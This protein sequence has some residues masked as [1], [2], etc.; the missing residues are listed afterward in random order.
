[1]LNNTLGEKPVQIAIQK[2]LSKMKNLEYADFIESFNMPE[3]NCG[4]RFLN[5][6]DIIYNW[7]ASEKYPVVLVRR[8]KEN[9]SIL[10]NQ[11]GFLLYL[12]FFTDFP[13]SRDTTVPRKKM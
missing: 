6:S 11:V 9:G 4:S 1:M 13:I 2:Y 10:L 8:N 7:L 12:V 3:I 5:V